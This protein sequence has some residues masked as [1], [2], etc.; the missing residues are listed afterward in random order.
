MPST[1]LTEGEL[2]QHFARQPAADW[3]DEGAPA[4]EQ[5]GARAAVLIP[6]VA[7]GAGLSVL[8]TRRT[9]HL[10]HHPGQISFPGGRVEAADANDISTALRETQ[11]EIGLAPDR[12]QILGQLPGYGTVTGFRI[13]PIVGLVNAP[14][15]LA[16]DAFEVAE[17][18][19][20]PLAHLTN[21]RNYQIHRIERAGLVR[22]FYAVPHAGRFIWGATAGMLAAFCAYVGRPL[23]PSPRLAEG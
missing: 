5:A 22:E 12:I 7:D 19:Q 18:F 16:L 9:D 21:P 2:R 1:P 4:P 10:Y 3:P 17:V 15:T 13:T 8:F 23:P 6:I 14:L 20:V 11:E